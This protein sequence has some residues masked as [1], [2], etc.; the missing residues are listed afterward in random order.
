MIRV[1]DFLQ[2]VG[3][4]FNC[5]MALLPLCPL[6]IFFRKKMTNVDIIRTLIQSVLK[7]ISLS[8]PRY[9]D[10]WFYFKCDNSAVKNWTAMPDIFPNGMES[11]YQGT[12][13][14]SGCRQ[15]KSV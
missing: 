7:V 2:G 10:S 8:H 11:V 9:L 5:K 6:Y 13:S 14:H 15:L 3:T 12:D 4:W 1:G